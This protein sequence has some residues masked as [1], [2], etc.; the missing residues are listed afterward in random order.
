MPASRIIQKQTSGAT[1]IIQRNTATTRSTTPSTRFV[2]LG[3]PMRSVRR[4]HTTKTMTA[5]AAAG[6]TDD[7][8]N[9]ECQEPAQVP[10]YFVVDG[11]EM[12]DPYPP[13]P[14]RP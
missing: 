5:T 7:A 10:N 13:R 14:S 1:P 9:F 2:A 6:S 3:H 11:P 4:A 8:A 12:D